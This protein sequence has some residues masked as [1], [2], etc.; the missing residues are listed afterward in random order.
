VSAP[1]R[2][3]PVS[4]EVDSE[5]GFEEVEA[6]AADALE[7]IDYEDWREGNL[8]RASFALLGLT[9]YSKRTRTYRNESLHTAMSDMLNDLHHLADLAGIDWEA[10]TSQHHYDDEIEGVI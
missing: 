10:V 9:A 2:L 6:A 8:T 7:H 3:Q 4:A 1:Y 5:V